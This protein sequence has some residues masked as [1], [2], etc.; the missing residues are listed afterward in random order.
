MS[1][2]AFHYSLC[3]ALMD[4]VLCRGGVQ[5]YD[6]QPLCL[7]CSRV[8]V[9]LV[10]HFP[11]AL[12]WGLLLAV[13]FPSSQRTVPSLTGLPRLPSPTIQLP[14]T[15]NA[16]LALPLDTGTKIVG[17]ATVRSPTGQDTTV[18]V[19]ALTTALSKEIADLR[20][21]LTLVRNEREAELR[22]NLL[23]YIQALPQP[24]LM[25]LTADMSEEVVQAMEM[26][27]DAL[28]SRLGVPDR[29][30]EVILQ[31]SVG[32]LAQICMWQIV[33]GYKLRELEA[34]ERGVALD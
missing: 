15:A 3:R 32:H 31:Q 8:F 14:T 25:R 1:A 33:V 11:T 27:V 10:V 24:E 4:N 34:L 12:F 17:E 6:T 16:T 5:R 9:V 28:M 29:Q 30:S 13:T 20:Q 22:A 7:C 26:L 23:T 21:E 2:V 18:D 19:E